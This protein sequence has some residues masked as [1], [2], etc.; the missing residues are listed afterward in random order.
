LREKALMHLEV[1]QQDSLLEQSRGILKNLNRKDQDPDSTAYY[2]SVLKQS[3]IQNVYSAPLVTNDLLSIDSSKNEILFFKDTLYVFY[4]NNK[5]GPARSSAIHLI[6]P[7]P[8]QV[9]INGSYFPPQEVFLF[10]YWA[11][12]ERI[13]NLMPLDYNFPLGTN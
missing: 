13:A 3:D 9:D 5:I 4:I 10:G 11:I 6:S 1:F 8:V 2:Y 7:I 12:S